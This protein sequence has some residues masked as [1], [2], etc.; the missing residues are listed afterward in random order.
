MGSRLIRQVW[1]DHHQAVQQEE[2]EATTHTVAIDGTWLEIDLCA[3]CLAPIEE[4]ATFLAAYG[5]AGGGPGGGKRRQKHATKDTPGAL[6]CPL[7]GKALGTEKSLRQH[8]RRQHDEPAAAQEQQ[9][10]VEAEELPP[11]TCPV[12]GF[13]AKSAQGLASHRTRMHRAT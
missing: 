8:L 6:S 12:C 10:Q 1:C 3:E 7:C 5:R 9:E 4:L 2:L 13:V 11:L